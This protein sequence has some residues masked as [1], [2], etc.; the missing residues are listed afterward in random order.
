MNI[1]LFPTRIYKYSHKVPVLKD[2]L[3]ERYNSWKDHSANGTPDGWSCD[4]RTEFHGAFPFREYEPYYT[5]ILKVWKKDIGC[6]D[7]PYISE[8]WLNAYEEQQFQESH[9]HLPGFY[10]AIHYVM[11]DPEVHESTTFQNPQENIQSFMFDDSFMD[12]KLNEHLKENYQPDVEEGD[13]IIFP[14][15][16]RHYVKRNTSRKLRMTISFNINRIAE[17]TRRVFA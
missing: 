15:H 5:D 7:N 10:S 11:F 16:L 9:T 3:L 8:I 2:K 17:S 4:V 14:S 13:L 12:P 1:D 6:S